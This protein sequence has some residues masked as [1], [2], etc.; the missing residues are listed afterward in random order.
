MLGVLRASIWSGVCQVS[1]QLGAYLLLR[2][3]RQVRLSKIAKPHQKSCWKGRHRGQDH[4]CWTVVEWHPQLFWRP[5][6]RDQS[7]LQ[8]NHRQG[9]RK[10]IGLLLLRRDVLGGIW[11]AE[12]AEDWI[13]VL[14]DRSQHEKLSSTA[15]IGRV[16]QDWLRHR[17]RSERSDQVLWTGSSAKQRSSHF[18]WVIVRL[19]SEIYEK[20]G[21]D[22]NQNVE[23]AFNY[24]Y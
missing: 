20:G 13:F 17:T 22:V 1:S 5:T 4:V 24:Y 3:T 9:R 19:F 6:C 16:L 18:A 14:H 15:E 2:Q 23:R 21:A 7:V 8:R 11:S 12:A 10:R